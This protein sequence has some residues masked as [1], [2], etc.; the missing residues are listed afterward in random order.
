VTVRLYLK[1]GGLLWGQAAR[2]A[3]GGGMAGLLAGGETGFTSLEVISRNGKAV[4]REWSPYSDIAASAETA[5]RSRLRTIEAARPEVAGLD[6]SAPCFMG[7]VNVTPDSFSDGGLHGEAEAAIGHGRALA[8]AG[9]SILDVGGEST[10][11]FSE[12]TPDDVE[13]ARVLPV[14]E[15]LAR[16]GR[17][18]SIDTRKPAV[19]RAAAN[20]GATIV[21]DV[22]ALGYDPDSLSTAKALGL[23]VI[24]MHAQGDP[25][26]MQ[27]DPRYDDVALDVF[28][29]LAAR[30]AICE[31]A[32]IPREMLIADPG[33]GF[34][35][36]HQQNLELLSCLTLFHGLGAPL[37][38]GASR[39]GFIGKLTGEPEARRRVMGSVGA[40]LSAAMQGAQIL[41]VHNVAETTATLA[42]WHAAMVTQSMDLDG[43]FTR[44]VLGSYGP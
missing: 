13:L 23:P 16:E 41:R 5:L 31:E 14:V 4:E 2:D 25:S 44:R 12:P 21:N 35:K 3:A 9:A 30:I 24:L 28:D 39:K 33:I 40:A 6:F 20:A 18:V 11:P 22:A 17:R 8:E 1:P 32:G 27:V 15:A 7:I 34:G 38:V 43:K 37:L 19:M 36:T 26:V 42:V 10:R 29:W